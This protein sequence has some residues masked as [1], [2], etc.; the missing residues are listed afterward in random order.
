MAVFQEKSGERA[1]GIDLSS[2]LEETRVLD[3]YL[4]TFVDYTCFHEKIEAQAEIR[5]SN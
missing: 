2:I 1:K 5:F 3:K 4:G